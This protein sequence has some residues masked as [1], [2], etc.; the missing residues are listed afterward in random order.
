VNAGV[1]AESTGNVDGDFGIVDADRVGAEPGPRQ[2]IEPEM[3][4]Q[5]KESLVTDITEF[6]R[7]DAA[8]AGA[9]RDEIL[10]ARGDSGWPATLTSCRPMLRPGERP[11]VPYVHRPG[12]KVEH[13]I[14]VY[15]VAHPEFDARRLAK[16]VIRLKRDGYRGDC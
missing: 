11:P 5:V 7:L 4:L 1:D 9:A 14:V 8:K 6:G 13:R 3:A 16:L 10:D 12:R 15:G 2:G